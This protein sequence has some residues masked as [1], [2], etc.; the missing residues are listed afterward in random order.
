M[1]FSFSDMI[2]V[3]SNEEDE[4]GSKDNDRYST[5]DLCFIVNLPPTLLIRDA[6]CSHVICSDF[7][8]G[9]SL[10]VLDSEM[11]YHSIKKT[12]ESEDQ[13]ASNVTIA[14]GKSGSWGNL[15][16]KDWEISKQ[17][18]QNCTQ[19]GD[20]VRDTIVLGKDC[21]CEEIQ[22]EEREEKRE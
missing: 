14:I 4:F 6:A 11:A 17:G 21:Y 10:W 15:V 22:E 3:E 7:S 16:S 1:A 13:T 19:T 20:S 12:E 5:E 2:N 18:Y 8:C 9:V